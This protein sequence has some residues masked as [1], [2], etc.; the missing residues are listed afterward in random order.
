MNALEQYVQDL[1]V[2]L[3]LRHKEDVARH[4]G[5]T[6]QELN[7]GEKRGYFTDALCCQIA[8]ELDIH[9]ALVFLARETVKEKNRK[10]S[11]YW[12]DA[13]SAGRQFLTVGAVAFAAAISQH[14]DADTLDRGA[15]HQVLPILKITGKIVRYSLRWI[16]QPFHTFSAFLNSLS[17]PVDYITGN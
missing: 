16:L 7:R 17:P 11:A 1:R 6:P 15:D 9:P 8:A 10:V 14:V 3:G 5:I 2:R 13:L 4:L 12:Q